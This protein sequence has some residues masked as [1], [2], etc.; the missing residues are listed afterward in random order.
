MTA[1]SAYEKEF[2]AHYDHS[3]DCYIYRDNAQTK[4]TRFVDLY[5]AKV[6]K[7]EPSQALTNVR[8]MHDQLE[9]AQQ[10]YKGTHRAYLIQFFADQFL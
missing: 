8:N 10:Y 5:V 1:N 9:T 6:E 4:I 2:C 7:Q 3:V